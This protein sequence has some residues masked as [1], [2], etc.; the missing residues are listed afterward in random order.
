MRRYN[1]GDIRLHSWHCPGT[2][3]ARVVTGRNA[4]FRRRETISL[5]C[6]FRR[7]LSSQIPQQLGLQISTQPTLPRSALSLEVFVKDRNDPSYYATRA[8]VA[9]RLA[10]KARDRAIKQIHEEMAREYEN[11]A[12]NFERP[13]LRYATSD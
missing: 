3:G 11:L 8:E 13:R 5:R 4:P 12:F 10:D 7:L 9:R 2:Q 1:I 6:N